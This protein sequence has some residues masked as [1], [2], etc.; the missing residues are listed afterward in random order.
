M[1]PGI[2]SVQALAARH[3]LP[4]N[5]IGE[6]VHIT[7]GRR[8]AG[9]LPDDVDSAVVM[10]DPGLACKDLDDPSLE[11]YWG[12]YVGTPDETL[13]SGRLSE[14]AAD[15]E[16]AKLALRNRHGWIMD[17]YLVRRP[18]GERSRANE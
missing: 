7:T 4:L 17:T 16:A 2:S 8:V 12:A 13:I 10:L 1:I 11:I 15:I 3:R 6:P 9:G 5:R 18:A 14:V